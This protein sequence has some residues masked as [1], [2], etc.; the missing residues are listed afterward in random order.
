MK[1]KEKHWKKSKKEEKLLKF[2][3][4]YFTYIYLNSMEFINK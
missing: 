4:F 2:F 3:F 1:Q